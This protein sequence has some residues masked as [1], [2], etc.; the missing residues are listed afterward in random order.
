LTTTTD[1][2]TTT[3]TTIPC[4][5]Y[6]MD[7]DPDPGW[8]TIAELQDDRSKDDYPNSEAEIGKGFKR[9]NSFYIGNRKLADLD[10][11]ILKAEMCIGSSFEEGYKCELECIPIEV[12]NAGRMSACLWLA[13]AF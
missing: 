1:T 8:I 2:T 4:K 13:S 9:E 5:D 10:G 7:C 11:K 6:R 12:K 3:T